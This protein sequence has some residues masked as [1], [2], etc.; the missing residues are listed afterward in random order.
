MQ[1]IIIIIISLVAGGYLLIKLELSWLQAF[2]QL[3]HV[4]YYLQIFYIIKPFIIIYLSN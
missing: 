3:M 1:L 4:G 2:R